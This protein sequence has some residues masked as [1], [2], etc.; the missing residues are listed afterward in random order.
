MDVE[1]VTLMSDVCCEVG[2]SIDAR[3]GLTPGSGWFCM[4][5]MPVNQSLTSR[6]VSASAVLHVRANFVRRQRTYPLVCSHM[7]W[8]LSSIGQGVGRSR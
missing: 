8:I 7:F 3:L 5:T 1:V 4:Y 2:E 6:S